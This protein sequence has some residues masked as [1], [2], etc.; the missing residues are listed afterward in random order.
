M[1]YNDLLN[2]AII[3]SLLEQERQ[4]QD[5]DLADEDKILAEVMKMSA[6]EYQKNTGQIDLSHL[7]RKNK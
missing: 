6:L 7:K 3:Q 5:P 1:M 4:A 2:E